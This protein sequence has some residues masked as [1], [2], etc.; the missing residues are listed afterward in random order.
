MDLNLASKTAVVTGAGR[1]IG[2][3]TVRALTAEGVRV[4][5]AA[6]TITPELQETGAHTVSADLST[7]EG[8]ATLIS[9]ALDT[10][11][12][13]DL[14]VNN[15]GGGDGLAPVGFLDSD[16]A[17]WT[18]ILD[19]NLLS[20]VRAT[21]AALPSLIER[22]GSIVN[23]SSISAREPTD[24]LVAYSAAKAA[25][26]SLGKALAREFGPQ[27]VRVNT[28]SPGAVNTFI[29]ASPDALG[30]AVAAQSG[31]DHAT[32]FQRLPQDFGIATGRITEP[33]EVAALIVFLLSDAAGN[34]TGADHLIDG[35]ALTAL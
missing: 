16:D 30:G 27:G 35:G 25:L 14:L 22:R 9:G 17:H 7:P 34:L 5:G 15:V 33:E 6:R 31:L 4:V 24:G 28:V 12:G 13:I 20:A 2:L 26:T 11:G 3:A 32:F 10:L 21:R 29:W 8:V 18:G 19:L 23:V 1:G